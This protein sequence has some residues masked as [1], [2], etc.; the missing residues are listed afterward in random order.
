MMMGNRHGHA[1][2]GKPE[3]VL[4]LEARLAKQYQSLAQKTHA[5]KI[6]K[7]SPFI[8]ADAAKEG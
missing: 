2:Q 1:A 7:A 4:F 3:C 6:W 8:V 5:Q